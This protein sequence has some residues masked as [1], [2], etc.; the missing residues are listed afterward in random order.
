[1]QLYKAQHIYPVSSLPITDGII[2]IEGE[3]IIAVGTVAEVVQHYPGAHVTD[4]GA[5][6]LMP[7]AV[8]AHTHLELTCLAELGREYSA[9]R[10]FVQWIRELVRQ[11]RAIPFEVQEEG[12]REGCRMLVESGT[13]AV[14]DIS[15]HKASLLPLLESGLYGVIYYEI[16]SPEPAKAQQ[17]F[18]M[19]REQIRRWRS[20]YGE[21]RIRLG[22]TLHTPFT[23]SPELFRL[24]APWVIE[25]EVPFCIHTAESPAETQY[26]LSGSGEIRDTLYPLPMPITK[27]ITPPECSPVAY[28]DRLGILTT[29]PLLIHGVYVDRDD[30]RLLARERIAMAHCPRSNFLLNCG[31]MPL[32]LYQEAGVLVTM[33]TDSLSSSPSLSVWE[34]TVSMMHTHRAAG[35]AIDV[36][37]ALRMCTLDGA[38]ALGFEQLLGSLEP[39][40]LARLAISQ[41]PQEGSADEMLRLL[42]EGQITVKTFSA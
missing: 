13:G 24:V 23:V 38:R 25:E 14:G 2:A 37:D 18:D 8:N 34:E 39:G 29:K 27:W 36:H 12:A 30:L 3:R 31:R 28:L 33:G 32:E 22:V 41:A 19:A 6:M 10:S 11:W 35:I 1:M 4:L 20:E 16:F 9:E 15:N 17:L 21:E 26:L 7:Q 42:W 40:K 5:V